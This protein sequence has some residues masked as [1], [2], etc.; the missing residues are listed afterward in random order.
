MHR[1]RSW[2]R[3]AAASPFSTTGASATPFTCDQVALAPTATGVYFL[4]RHGRVIYVGVAVQGSGL[5]QELQRHLHGK[6]G[7]ATRVATAF[8]YELTRDPVVASG[9]YLRAHMARHRGRLPPCNDGS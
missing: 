8:D 3:Q 7:A 1:I 9:E 4:Y 2:P 6:Y 5:R